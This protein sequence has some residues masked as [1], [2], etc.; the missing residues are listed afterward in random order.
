MIGE[1][2]YKTLEAN[3][4]LQSI[5]GTKIFP[6]RGTEEAEL[7][8][9]VYSKEDESKLE[10]SGMV[11]MKDYLMRVSSYSQDYDEAET[12]ADAIEDALTNHPII[13]EGYTIEAVYLEDSDNGIDDEIGAYSFD[14]TFKIFTHKNI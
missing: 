12:M 9:I 10:P 1:F 3:E 11:V 6:I 5:V 2:I 14:Q 13:P 8:A 4:I 7:P